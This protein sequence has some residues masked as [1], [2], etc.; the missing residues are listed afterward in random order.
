MALKPTDLVGSHI[1]EGIKQYLVYDGSGRL[2]D[3]YVA[4]E[5]AEDGDPCVRTQYEY[6]GT[7]NRVVKMKEAVAYWDAT[8][9]I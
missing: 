6:D 8:W 4:I 9:D 1:K 7:S 3:T 2:T 5:A